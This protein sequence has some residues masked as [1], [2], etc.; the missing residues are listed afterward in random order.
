MHRWSNKQIMNNIYNNKSFIQSQEFCTT[1]KTT[2]QNN[3]QS[4]LNYN[5]TQL[6]T[7]LLINNNFHSI[8]THY[9]TLLFY[10]ILNE[11]ATNITCYFCQCKFTGVKDVKC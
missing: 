9:N 5:E 8:A 10:Y 3:I 4:G 2:K 6:I 1:L 7:A 11:Y